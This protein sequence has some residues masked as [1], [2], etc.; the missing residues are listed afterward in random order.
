MR[1][2]VL[3]AAITALPFFVNAAEDGFYGTYTLISTSRTR[4]DTG[5]VETFARGR[6]FITYGKDGRMMVIIVR[7]DRPK[8]E[9]IEKRMTDHQRA[10]L[11]RLMTAYGGTYRFDGK[12]MEHR[13]DISWNELW[14]GTTRFREM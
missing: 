8:A 4:L 14:T 7:G 5:Q 2:M 11:H 6:G 12:T 3:A 9:S 1:K 13:I 10:E